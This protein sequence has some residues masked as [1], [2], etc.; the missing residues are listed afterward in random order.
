MKKILTVLLLSSFVFAKELS[1]L[2]IIELA[3][4]SDMA[5]ISS[6][7]SEKDKLSFESSQSAYM[8]NLS[9]QG[10]YKR[11]NAGLI[12]PKSAFEIEARINFL[13]Y[14]GGAREANLSALKNL[15]NSS[16][17]NNKHIQNELALKAVKLYFALKS[18]TDI[19]KA[20]TAEIEYL[21]ALKTRLKKLYESGLIPE[22]ELA[23]VNTKYSISL[24]Q[25]TN[26]KR[27]ESEILKDIWLLTQN[28]FNINLSQSLVEPDYNNKTQSN[29]KIEALKFQNLAAKEGVNKAKAEF[30]PTLFLQ[31]G[32]AWYKRK[33]QNDMLGKAFSLPTEAIAQ[34]KGV[35]NENEIFKKKGH[36]NEIMLGFSWDIFDF[37]K[38]SK[39]IQIA[40]IV[41]EQSRLT[42]EHEILK[43][44][45]NLKKIKD[46]IAS[47]NAQI[48]AQKEAIDAAIYAN[49]TSKKRYEA[50]LINYS[51]MLLSLARVYE[52]RSEYALGISELEIKKAEYFYEN[53]ES[54]KDKIK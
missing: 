9:L 26:L 37:G 25:M 10:G 20:K 17:Y 44:D 28:E 8:P 3:Q 33:Y 21:Q 43:N 5:K 2:E 42:L 11:T 45:I 53:G 47:L 39:N 22:D 36:Y 15:K 29:P 48:I 24:S 27:K 12:I 23:N 16:I 30:F 32:V 49:N 46:N 52:A 14:D 1:L 18:M 19:I 41:S 51:D 54:I 7:N 6:L 35:I 31:G 40:K 38:S 34:Y 13:I 4:S 50:G